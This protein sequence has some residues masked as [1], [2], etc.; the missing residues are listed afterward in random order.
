MKLGGGKLTT[1]LGIDYERANDD[2]QGYE[3]F[4]GLT[5]GVKGALRR[6]EVD[7]RD[8]CRPVCPGRMAARPTG[9]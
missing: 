3:N 1:T 7:R 2:R 8:Q 4:V 6:D 5:L 9:S